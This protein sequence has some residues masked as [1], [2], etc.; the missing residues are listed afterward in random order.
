MI[1]V[2]NSNVNWSTHS[3]V[4]LSVRTID[5]VNNALTTTYLHF[6]TIAAGGGTINS[7][8]INTNKK[9]Q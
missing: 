9:K 1:F 3:Q 2:M 5:K 4:Y 7:T 8:K 6:T